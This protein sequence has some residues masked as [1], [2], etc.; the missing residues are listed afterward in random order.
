M[1]RRPLRATAADPDRAAIVAGL[2][3]EECPAGSN[4]FVHWAARCVRGPAY[5][6]WDRI[7]AVFRSLPREHRR[8]IVRGRRARRGAVERAESRRAYLNTHPEALER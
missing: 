2:R 1:K 7:E 3:E 8:E 5:P 4:P 6:L